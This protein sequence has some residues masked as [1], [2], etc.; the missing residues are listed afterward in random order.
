[1]KKLLIVLT[2]AVMIISGCNSIGNNAVSTATPYPD[3]VSW[4]LA[5]EILYSGE[6]ETVIQLHNLTVTL[7]LKD[8]TEIKTIEPVI[9]AIFEEVD[10]CGQPCDNIALAME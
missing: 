5:V 3:E 2:L 7:L 10:K 4:E 8:G 6:V 1:M 9:D